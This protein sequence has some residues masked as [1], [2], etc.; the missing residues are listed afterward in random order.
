M[1]KGSKAEFPLFSLRAIHRLFF[2]FLAINKIHRD[3]RSN[4]IALY[5]IPAEWITF[6]LD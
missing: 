6:F 2:V 5:S 4:K 1:K 3:N